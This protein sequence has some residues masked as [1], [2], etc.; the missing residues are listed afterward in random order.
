MDRNHI[1]TVGELIKALGQ[2]DPLLPVG[3]SDDMGDLEEV[4]G[5]SLHYS[6]TFVKIS[7]HE[8][9][10][11]KDGDISDGQYNRGL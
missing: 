11:R 8:G 5:V 9:W 2:F 7:I 6:G 1:M 10:R 3:G 4:T